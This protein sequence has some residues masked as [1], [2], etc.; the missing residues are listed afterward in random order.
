[1][2]TKE[3][4]QLMRWMSLALAGVAIGLAP[5]RGAAG[6]AVG[7]S[8][9]VRP[10]LPPVSADRPAVEID[11]GRVGADTAVDAAGR[12]LDPAA[13]VD[14]EA[15][16]GVRASANPPAAGA[17][18]QG[19]FDLGVLF[20]PAQTA[21]A[22]RSS[23]ALDRDAVLTDIELRLDSSI[24]ASDDLRRTARH[25]EGK[26]KAQFKQALKEVRATHK[27]AK[28]S[29]KAARRAPAERWNEAREQLAGDYLAH[30]KALDGLSTAAHGG[31]AA[32]G[33][34]TAA[35]PAASAGATGKAGTDAPK[36]PT[37]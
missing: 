24:E 5:A 21:G 35:P 7:A 16:A 32:T 25:L 4:G 27:A 13:R 34:A 9:A 10:A 37:P 12:P 29:L 17:E 36:P 14:A 18:G 31:A 15:E 28:A 19:G 6:V 30:A 23:S 26:A 20:S 22:L 2:N 1:M 8:G 11:G 33:D 3:P